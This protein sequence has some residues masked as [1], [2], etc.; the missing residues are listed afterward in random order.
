MLEE[1]T[2]MRDAL[3]RA[4]KVLC[5]F[6]FLYPSVCLGWGN[7]GHKIV[8]LAAAKL[9]ASDSPETLAKLNSILSMD[10]PT[11]WVGANVSVAKDIASEATWADLLRENSDQGRQ[12]TEKWHFVD[13]DFDHPD[14]RN[15][16][17]ENPTLGAG[18]AASHAP[19]LDCVAD[20]IDQFTK[21]LKDPQ[22]PATERL[23][24]LKFLLHFVGDIHQ[25][26]HAAT[27][28][29]PQIGHQDF[30][31][32]CVGILRGK[33]KTPTRLHSYWDTTLVEAAL[34]KDENQAAESLMSLVTP[35]SKQEWAKG[36]ASSWAQESYDLAKSSAYAGVVDKTPTQSAFVFKTFQG[37]PDKRCGFSKV[38]KIDADYDKQATKVVKEQLARAAVRLAWILKEN[39]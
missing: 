7:E 15:A 6:T 33:A 13:I 32:N 12:V 21:E 20:K 10:S 30:G 27:R 29:D 1:G 3:R 22:T 2:A 25:P 23:L 31:G 28:T 11:A 4:T 34:G 8:A 5:V 24:A 36:S 38:Y 16:C 35:S 18:E 37:G 26:L 14:I 17:F 19:S 9:L 39:L